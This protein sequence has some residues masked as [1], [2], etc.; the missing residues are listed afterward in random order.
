MIIDPSALEAY[1]EVMEDE[2]D[3][4]I[5]D[6]LNSFYTILKMVIDLHFQMFES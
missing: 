6:V 3:E 5:A 1:R 4:F 2:A